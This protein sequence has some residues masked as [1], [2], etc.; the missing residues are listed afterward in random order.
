MKLVAFGALFLPFVL[1]YDGL[2][3]GVDPLCAPCLNEVVADGPSN[4]QSKEFANYLC[5]GL[6]ASAVGLCISECGISTSGDIMDQAEAQGRSAIITGIV[7]DYCVQYYPEETCAAVEDTKFAQLPPCPKIRKGG[8]NG[9]NDSPGSDSE[10]STLRLRHLRPLRPLAL[11]TPTS[12]TPLRAPTAPALALSLLAHQI[13]AHQVL[14]R[15]VL[16][17]HTLRPE[18]SQLLWVL[19]LPG[20]C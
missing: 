8:G 14:A 1:A 17:A 7:F 6:G 19:L 3:G 5:I 4:T 12:P 20:R 9:G 10:D 18:V 15:E 16:A 2:F 11:A 13:L